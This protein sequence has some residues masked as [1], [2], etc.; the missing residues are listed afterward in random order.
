MEIQP[1]AKISD[2]KIIT[3]NTFTDQRGYLSEMF[4]CSEFQGLGLDFE[5]KQINCSFTK[6]KGTLRGLH[7]QISPMEQSKIV[8]CQSG[9]IFDVAVDL[10]PNSPT[11]SKFVSFLMFGEFIDAETKKFLMEFESDYILEPFQ[12]VLIPKGFAHGFLSLADNTII[13]YSLDEEFSKSHDRS[14]LWCDETIG[15]NWPKITSQFILSEKD[16]RAPKLLD[17]FNTIAL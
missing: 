3:M 5:I 11:F 2:V 14:L 8:T 13:I 6:S 12:S 4:K 10:R 9:A 15:I 7:F 16:R 1:T 17:L